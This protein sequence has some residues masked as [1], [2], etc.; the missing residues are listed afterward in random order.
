[1]FSQRL[2]NLKPFWAGNGEALAPVWGW[3]R[4]SQKKELLG[5]LSVFQ[6]ILPASHPV[7]P[8]S[9]LAKLGDWMQKPLLKNEHELFFP[10]FD[11]IIHFAASDK[12]LFMWNLPTPPLG[13]K[14][15]LI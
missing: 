13:R 5:L 14:A 4:S 1:M 9:L 6:L 11:Q 7:P 8:P 12:S 2:K 10:L 3:D 15:K